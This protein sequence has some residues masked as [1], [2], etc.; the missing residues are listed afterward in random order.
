MEKRKMNI[1][2]ELIG[3]IIVE[4]PDTKEYIQKKL[5]EKSEREGILIDVAIFFF[6]KFSEVKTFLQTKHIITFFI[7]IC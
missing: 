4:Y 2:L 1:L 5:Q 7:L 3:D 6:S